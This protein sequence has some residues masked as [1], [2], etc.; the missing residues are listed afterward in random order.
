LLISVLLLLSTQAP[1]P[2]LQA[3][4]RTGID[5]ALPLE[6]RPMVEK[7]SAAELDPKRGTGNAL[8]ILKAEK[9]RFSGLP[10][11]SI[12]L[13]LRIAATV[14]RSK[15]LQNQAAPEPVRYSQ[16]LSTYSKLDLSEPGLGSWIDRTIDHTPAV[17]EKIGDKKKRRLTIAVL[18]QGSGLEKD[19]IFTQVK[20]A[21]ENAGVTVEKSTAKQA[22]YVLTFGAL[23]VRDEGVKSTVRVSMQ[24]EAFEAEK[25]VWRHSLFRTMESKE[26]KAALASAVEWLVR[27]GGRDLLFHW[28][29]HHGIEG[30][31][32]RPEEHVHE[33]P[34]PPRG[35]QAPTGSP[36]VRIDP[37]AGPR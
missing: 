31:V 10:E 12:A 16:A 8:E 33:P 7:A 37:G 13:D 5:P 3:R 26:A 27:I 23:D 14:L 32:M 11:T 9:P 30:A 18:A 22:D 35:A 15:F 21:F 2:E 20:K 25:S 36:K 1:P 28:L 24:I 19:A 4:Q 29:E 34:P 6:L 17:K